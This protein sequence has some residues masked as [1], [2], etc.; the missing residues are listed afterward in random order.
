[1]IVDTTTQKAIDKSRKLAAELFNERVSIAVYAMNVPGAW[2]GIVITAQDTSGHEVNLRFQPE[3]LLQMPE[4][5]VRQ[6]LSY[7]AEELGRKNFLK[8][9]QS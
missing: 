7:L 9:T 5:E 2:A 8:P 3:Y 1:M 4:P 6:Y